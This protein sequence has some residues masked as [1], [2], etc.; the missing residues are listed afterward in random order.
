MLRS[1][2]ESEPGRSRNCGRD[3]LTRYLK[4]DDHRLLAELIS[5]AAAILPRVCDL[6]SIQHQIPTQPR[7]PLQ[8]P[9]LLL[10]RPA[11]YC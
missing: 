11:L 6:H 7:E 8:N 2:L 9:Q 4:L 5:G 10:H 3:I 1:F